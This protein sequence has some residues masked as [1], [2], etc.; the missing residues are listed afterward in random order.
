MS[1][2][3]S[4]NDSQP[5]TPDRRIRAKAALDFLSLWLESGRPAVTT[6]LI[7]LSVRGSQYIF[8]TYSRGM[9]R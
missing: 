5:E 9:I 6:M 3:Q 8:T 7:T 2:K 1:A 4:G